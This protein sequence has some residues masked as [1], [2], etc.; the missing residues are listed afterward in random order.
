MIAMKRRSYT[1]SSLQAVP[2]QWVGHSVVPRMAAGEYRLQ[3]KTKS[4]VVAAHPY[5]RIL[6]PG[7]GPFTTLS[8]MR[9]GGMRR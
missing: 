4:L 6:V 8:Y 1:E 7:F 2:G 3:A 5:S 9:K